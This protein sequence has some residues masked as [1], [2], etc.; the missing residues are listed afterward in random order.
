MSDARMVLGVAI[1]LG[2]TGTSALAKAQSPLMNVDSL[3]AQVRLL[4]SVATERS[5]ILDS[6]RRAIVRSAPP[7][8][9]RRGALEVRTVA[10]LE[11]RVSEAVDSVAALIDREG[12]PPLAARVSAH[13]PVVRPDSAR[14]LFGMLHIVTILPDTTRRSAPRSRRPIMASAGARQLADDLTGV[15]EHF[16]AKDVDSSL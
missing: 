8:A 9:V 11:A 13:V 10:S 6:M 14:A 7:V 3:R 12:G 4:D 5:R 1:A 15:I 2:L 16:A